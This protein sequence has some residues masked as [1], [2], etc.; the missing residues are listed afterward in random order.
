MKRLGF[1]SRTANGRPE[2]RHFHSGN[3]K[4]LFKNNIPSITTITR[5]VVKATFLLTCKL[6]RPFYCHP[7]ISADLAAA[8]SSASSDSLIP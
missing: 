8:S 2:R 4:S 5:L 3:V 1:L 7:K 6:S